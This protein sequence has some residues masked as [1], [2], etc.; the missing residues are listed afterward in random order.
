MSQG[1]NVEEADRL[2]RRRARMLPL[3]A[4][5]FITQQAAYVTE[6][7][8]GAGA[9]VR[10]VDHVKIGAWLILSV[11]LLLA[12]TTGGFWFKSREVRALLDD[13][14]T[15]AHRAAA[16]QLGFVVTMVAAFAMY[17]LIQFE[18]ISARDSIH[19]LV[20]IGIGTALVRF[21]MLERRAHL[22]D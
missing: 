11:V 7:Y 3:L 17:L 21:G 18:P 5:I 15:R 20:T 13:E 4:V 16:L 6:R 19:L 2:S 1:S 8:E 9:A 14:V 12:L 22:G 10:T